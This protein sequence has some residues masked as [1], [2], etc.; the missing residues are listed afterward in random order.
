MPTPIN[1]KEEALDLDKNER[2]E[3]TLKLLD[4]LEGETDE[5]QTMDKWVK[6]AETRYRA[7]KRGEVKTFSEEEATKRVQQHLEK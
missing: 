2:I 7:W 4:S 3:L 5:A 1:I 6:E